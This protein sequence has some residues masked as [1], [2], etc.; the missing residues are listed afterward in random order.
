MHDRA[1]LVRIGTSEYLNQL[2][3]TARIGSATCNMA[4]HAA[5]SRREGLRLSFS[6]VN[7]CRMAVAQGLDDLLVCYNLATAHAAL[8]D[9]AVRQAS[10]QSAPGLAGSC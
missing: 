4:R 8:G 2:R 7:D 3:A 1:P 6:C 9:L 10:P 5:A